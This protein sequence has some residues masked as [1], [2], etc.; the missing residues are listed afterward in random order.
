SRRRHTIFSRDW[1]SDVCSSDLTKSL[2]AIAIILVAGLFSCT[3]NPSSNQGKYKISLTFKPGDENKI[4]EA[5]LS[6]KDS[7]DILLKAGV[8]SEERRVGKEFI[9]FIGVIVKN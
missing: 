1:S 6:I 2:F 7:T 3:S 8:R 9:Y 4:E 5:F